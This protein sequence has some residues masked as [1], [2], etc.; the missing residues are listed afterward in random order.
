MQY[1]PQRC[2]LTNTGQF[3]KLGYRIFE[4][5]GRELHFVKII[6]LICASSFEYE[7]AQF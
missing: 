5:G 3:G 4:Q 1:Q 6:G 7:V 2:F